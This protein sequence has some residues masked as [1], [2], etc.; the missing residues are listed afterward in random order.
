[1]HGH[2]SIH[3]P[4]VL[5]LE[6]DCFL[7]CSPLGDSPNRLIIIIKDMHH[8]IHSVSVNMLPTIYSSYEEATSSSNERHV[9]VCLLVK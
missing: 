4:Y 2:M 9:Q 6:C 5:L 3:L 1:M 8:V 7:A